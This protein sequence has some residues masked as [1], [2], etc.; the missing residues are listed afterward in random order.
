MRLLE[1]DFRTFETLNLKILR[2]NVNF[3]TSCL[4]Q[5]LNLSSDYFRQLILTTKLSG[6]AKKLERIPTLTINLLGAEI[7]I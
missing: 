1:L 4:E 6:V 3:S 7:G 2:E 5:E